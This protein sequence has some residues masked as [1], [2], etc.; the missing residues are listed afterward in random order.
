MQNNTNL[1]RSV[2]WQKQLILRGVLMV[3]GLLLGL[4]IKLV[5]SIIGFLDVL[6]G[7]KK[8]FIKAT[9]LDQVHAVA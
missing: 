3:G 5:G 7:L 1:K 2:E 8:F 6:A 4:F 9:P